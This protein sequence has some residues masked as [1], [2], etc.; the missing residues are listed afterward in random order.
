MEWGEVMSIALAAI[1]GG[2]IGGGGIAGLGYLALKAKLIND[3]SS[4]FA[5]TNDVNN[6][7]GRITGA[8]NL[9]TMAKDTA[10][11]NRDALIRL[12]ASEEHKWPPLAKLIDKVD[13]RLDQTEA[14]MIRMTSTLEEVVRRL[15]RHDSHGRQ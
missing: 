9:A 13:H 1:I 12:Q 7:G 11:T 5:S 14:N 2:V 10:D 15:D 3:L 6:L 8:I 4:T